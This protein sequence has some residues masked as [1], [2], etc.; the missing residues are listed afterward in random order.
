MGKKNIL[1]IS[2]LGMMIALF[3]VNATYYMKSIDDSWLPNLIFIYIIFYSIGY[4]PMPWILMPQI[5]TRKVS[6]QMLNL[7]VLFNCSMTTF[8][9]FN[10]NNKHIK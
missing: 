3:L 4:G 8:H 10:L 6:Y 7:N 9:T 5:C 1:I 2:G